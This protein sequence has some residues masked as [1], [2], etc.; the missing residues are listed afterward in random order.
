MVLGIRSTP[1]PRWSPQPLIPPQSPQG[2]WR[3]GVQPHQG[4]WLP[5]L[6]AHRV[7]GCLVL[8]HRRPGGGNQQAE[9]AKPVPVSGSHRFEE[10]AAARF[11]SCGRT[12]N[13]QVFCWGPNPDGEIGNLPV[14]ST[15]RFRRPD[16][17]PGRH[18]LSNGGRWREHVLRGHRPGT[19]GVLGP[20]DRRSNSGAATSAA[21]RPSWCPEAAVRRPRSVG[22]HLGFDDLIRCTKLHDQPFRISADPAAFRS[23][24]YTK[25]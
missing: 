19:G 5:Y 9:S 24:Q 17:H 23:S 18:G 10:L 8:G 22:C 2:H 4:R 16:D 1:D 11:S 15:S 25:S 21:R 3:T 7:G 20:G 6:C 12:A 14:G 13:G